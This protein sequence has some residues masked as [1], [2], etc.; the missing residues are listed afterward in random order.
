[1][2]TGNSQL[3]GPEPL[4]ISELR[5]NAP[6]RGWLLATEVIAR[7]AVNGKLFLDLKLHD[8]RG[9][10]ITGR[11]FDPP[12]NEALFPQEGKV[13]LIEG[14]LEKYQNQLHIKLARARTDE[15]V[16]PGLFQPRARH[17]LEQ[18]EEMFQYLQQRIVHPGLQDLLARCFTPDTLARFRLWPAAVRH[19]GAVVGG[20]LE[21]TVHVGLL[22]EKMARLY[23]CNE[24]LVLA[25]TLL[26]D[27]GKLE[28]LEEQPGKGLTPRGR[29]Y[30]HIV[31]GA[32]YVEEQARY[33]SE[34]EESALQD[35]L[36]IILAHHG[37][38]EF[39]S[40]VC[41]VTIE[42]LIVHLADMAEAKLTGFLDH[43]ERTTDTKGWSAYN[44]E[45]GGQLRV[46]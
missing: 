20:L 34:L 31:L 14:A 25:G 2:T 19:H 17:P 15:A 9:N 33:V 28:E 7:K 43:C 27:I 5:M 23:R 37:T 40:P 39:G 35:L 38:R 12:G 1:M 46:P 42:A 8:A 21:H 10:E 32:Q 13:A 16:S 26:H 6:V 44:T 29:M 30:G 11:F 24:D 18:L 36:H 22:A 45:F 3:Q 4:V 41:P